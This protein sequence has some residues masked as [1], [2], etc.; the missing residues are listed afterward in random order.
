MKFHK[1]PSTEKVVEIR[2]HTIEWRKDTF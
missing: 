1:D 2:M